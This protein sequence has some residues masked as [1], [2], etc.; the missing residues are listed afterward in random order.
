MLRINCFPIRLSHIMW[1]TVD[2]VVEDG[3]LLRKTLYTVKRVLG[4]GLLHYLCI[5]FPLL[6]SI[7]LTRGIMD[8]ALLV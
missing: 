8:K 7:Y 6:N 2:R 4:K 5:L 1:Q 3:F